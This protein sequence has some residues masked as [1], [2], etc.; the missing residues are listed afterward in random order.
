[1]AYPTIRLCSFK[2]KSDLP[3]EKIYVM[4]FP[5]KAK[6]V[7]RQITAKRDNTVIDKISLPVKSLYKA[8]RLIRGLIHIGKISPNAGEFWLYSPHQLPTKSLSAILSYWIDTE[9]PDEPSKKGKVGITFE[10]RQLVMSYLSPEELVWNPLEVS[11]TNHLE[12]YSNGKP[13][14]YRVMILF[15]YLTS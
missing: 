1:M 7:I 9:F 13:L 14:T 4:S 10:E 3:K 15:C 12:T 11:Y 6:E 5:E 8:L 2:A